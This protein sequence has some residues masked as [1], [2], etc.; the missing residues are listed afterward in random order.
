MSSDDSDP[1]PG[2]GRV[3]RDGASVV[4]TSNVNGRVCS[5]SAV[6]P[7]LGGIL[8]WNAAETSWDCPLH[9]SRFAADGSLLEGMATRD[10]SKVDD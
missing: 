2:E 8:Q 5:V 3:H 10:L 4:A 6:C 9:G 7:H 1:A